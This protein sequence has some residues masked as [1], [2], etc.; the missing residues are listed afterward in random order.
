MRAALFVIPSFLSPT[1]IRFKKQESFFF[2]PLVIMIS[3]RA[4]AETSLSGQNGLYLISNKV[5]KSDL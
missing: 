3:K 5:L 4:S 2:S 1:S